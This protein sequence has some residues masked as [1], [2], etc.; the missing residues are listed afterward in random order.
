MNTLLSKFF[1]KAL[2]ITE[3]IGLKFNCISGI[4]YGYFFLTISFFDNCYFYYLSHFVFGIFSTIDLSSSSSWITIGFNTFVI[5]L[6]WRYAWFFRIISSASFS[7]CYLCIRSISLSMLLLNACY[8][9]NKEWSLRSAINNLFI[10]DKKFFFCFE[11][12]FSRVIILE[13][14]AFP[15]NRWSNQG[16]EERLLLVLLL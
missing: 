13:F 2:Y 9:S 15:C 11:V 7:F 10:Y 16:S 8:R 6:V 5:F 3:R 12:R 4:F 1:C 14:V